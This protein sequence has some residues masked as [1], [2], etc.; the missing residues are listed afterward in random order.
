MYI[1]YNLAEWET[2]VR[3]LSFHNIT[4]CTVLMVSAH[5]SRAS[6]S[7]SSP[8]RGLCFAFL[9]KTLFSNS[10]SLHPGI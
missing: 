6:G 3:S 2:R 5:D 9:G 1:S 8:E 4:D 7:G 10:V